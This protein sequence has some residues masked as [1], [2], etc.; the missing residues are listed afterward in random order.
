MSCVA[1]PRPSNPLIARVD[2]VTLISQEIKE[3]M[4]SKKKRNASNK[5]PK[6]S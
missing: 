3:L 6:Q 1:S 2:R 5:G 4:W